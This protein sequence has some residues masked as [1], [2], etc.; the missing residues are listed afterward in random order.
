MQKSS[1]SP[2]LSIIIFALFSIIYFAFRLDTINHIW[3]NGFLR[4]IDPD[5][6]YHLRRIVYCIEH[7]PQM[8]NH[9]AFLS[10]PEGDYVPWPPLFDFLSAS[11][12]KPIS[13]YTKVLPFLDSIYFFFAFISLYFFIYKVDGIKTA[14]IAAFFYATTNIL[15]YYTAAGRLDHHAL[16]LLII[17]AIYTTFILYYNKK[18]VT[19][20]LLFTICVLAA[21]FNW[22][23]AI[24][25]FPPLIIFV[26]YKLYKN[27]IDIRIFKGLF[28]AFHIAAILIAVYLR[29]T[30]EADYPPYSYKFFS[31]F[32]RDFC[33]F[34][35]IVFFNIYLSLKKTFSLKIIW[36]IAVIFLFSLFYKFIF[37]IFYGFAFVGKTEPILVL[38]EEVSPLFGSKFY[39]LGGELKRA[40]SLFTPLFFLLPIVFYRYIKIKGFDIFFIY[41]SYFCLLLFFQLRFGYFFMLGYAYML[42]IFLGEFLKNL[43][44][45]HLVG[46]AII[47]STV[48]FLINI[49]EGNGRFEKES[50]YRGL[51][52]LKNNTPE[53]VLFEK[54]VTP[55]GVLSSWHLGHYIIQLGNRPAVAHNF[56]GVAENNNVKAFIEALFAKDESSVLKIME[57]KKARFLLLDNI[58]DNIITDWSAISKSQNPYVK[59]NNVLKE[60]SLELFLYRLYRYNGMV[61]PFFDTPQHLRLVYH[62]N[63]IKIFE[64][65]K[66]FRKIAKE[67]AILKAKISSPGG[68]FLYISAGKKE[69]GKVVFNFPYSIDAPYPVKATEIYLEENGKRVS[70]NITEDMIH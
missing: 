70:L 19:Y 38:V 59:N 18:T 22:P 17:A 31:A 33:F 24:I 43:K 69:N 8:L 13:G 41:T 2:F 11:L 7:Y 20:L 63:D 37:E 46:S 58:E 40:A 9:D 6:Y 64:R 50:L 12:I 30:R 39:S 15:R 27:D 3:G 52:F 26:F 4:L 42:A 25:Y 44:K 62:N 56:I 47:I 57:E 16:E 51:L 45:Y 55:Y 21:F 5:S 54:G 34:T 10:Y 14:I 49:K 66:S 48:I 29:L 53:K 67:G 28:V 36:S 68:E 32:Q 35:S 65:V 61:P 60:K 23:G 1:E